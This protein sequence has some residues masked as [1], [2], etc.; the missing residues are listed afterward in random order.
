[1]S[2]STKKR[3]IKKS[4]PKKQTGRPKSTGAGVP[5]VVRAHPPLIKS[6]DDWIG[7]NELSRPEAI[8]QLVVWA[9]EQAQARKAAETA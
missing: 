7:D 1:M 4:P 5:L 9:L 8:R 6:L 2:K 3:V